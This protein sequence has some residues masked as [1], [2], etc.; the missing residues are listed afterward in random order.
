MISKLLIMLG[1][2]SVI[3]L[4]MPKLY[5][6]YQKNKENLP[7]HSTPE[8]EEKPTS[9]TSNL[10]YKEAETLLASPA[11]EENHIILND[12]L[13]ALNQSLKSF[14]NI[15]RNLNPIPKFNYTLPTFLENTINSSAL[16]IAR[17][18]IEL[19]NSKYEE[20][21]KKANNITELTSNYIQNY[22]ILLDDI[23]EELNQL[24]L[25]FEN[26]IKNLS[27]PLV[28]EQQ[29]SD[30]N[31]ED[32]NQIRRLDDLTQSIKDFKDNANELGE[33][34]NSFFVFCK[35]SFQNLG[36]NVEVII[37]D[38]QK[39]TNGITKAFLTYNNLLNLTNETNLHENLILSKNSFSSLKS[40]MIDSHKKIE[41]TYK[42]FE[43]TYTSTKFD[44]DGFKNK[45]YEILDN[46]KSNSN[47]IKEEIA[48]KR[49]DS[50]LPPI[51]I[52]DL[53]IPFIVSDSLIKKIEDLYIQ[54]IDI[55]KKISYEVETI[56]KEI[57][58]ETKTSLD[59]LFIMDITGS[60]GGFLETAKRNLINIIN[61]IVSECPGID[62]NIGFIGYRDIEEFS[63][64]DYTDIDFTPN[65]TKVLETI[66]N[67]YAYGGG[68]GPEDVAGAFE[69]ALNKT[70]KNNAR[71]AVLVADAPC[72]GYY[73]ID[74]YYDDYPNG[75]PG[76]KNISDLVEEFADNN[77]ALFCMRISSYTDIMFEMFKNIYEKHK[78][79]EF[80]IGNMDYS[81]QKFADVVV[82]EASKVYVNQRNIDSL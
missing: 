66:E 51:D 4:L 15:T 10:T 24:I 23:K 25:E 31:K 79:I 30:D 1:I 22:T 52:P 62:I 40:E 3:A 12:S 56:V 58:V 42:S 19:Y 82:E 76:R 13:L 61:R 45:Y 33:L 74:E 36:K 47:S 43:S 49:K 11:M 46:L 27:L 57:D 41:E 81:D 71:F 38:T 5:R 48:N 72:H 6:Q 68:D 14:S 50:N 69:M 75:V 28:L 60:M 18:D 80:H 65:Y 34:L 63:V 77:I 70:W 78:N 53:N 37:N 16:N 2:L 26:I 7:I 32:N 55:Q 67:V 64:G 54:I 29:L 59:L 44:F 17:S 39:V 20:L 21:S 35:S 73:C 9:L 8:E